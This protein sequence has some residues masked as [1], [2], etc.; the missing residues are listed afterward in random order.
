MNFEAESLARTTNGAIATISA[1]DTNASGGYYVTLNGDG[2]GDYIEFTLTNV[3]AGTYH[4]KLVFRSGSN[5]GQ[6]G[7]KLDG[8]SLGGTLDEYWPIG[9]YPLWDFGAVTFSS[10]GDH[11]IRFT[12]TGKNAASSSYTITADKF[13]LAPQ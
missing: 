4:L 3:P 2:A 12:V 7:L 6:L 8:N 9:A 1:V 13:M 11:T 10:T 5:R